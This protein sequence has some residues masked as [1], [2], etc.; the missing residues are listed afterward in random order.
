MRCSDFAAARMGVIDMKS[1]LIKD[2]TKEERIFRTDYYA[3]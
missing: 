2:T 1:I 3:G